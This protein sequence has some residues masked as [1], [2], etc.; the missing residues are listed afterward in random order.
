[1][2][3]MKLSRP[4]LMLTAIL[5]LES[6]VVAGPLVP[7]AGTS[8]SWGYYRDSTGYVTVD[9]V[10][11][12]SYINLGSSGPSFDPGSSVS[13]DA[14]VDWGYLTGYGI[15]SR[16]ATISEWYI[17][18]ISPYSY[19]VDSLSFS[20]VDP[21]VGA[22][23]YAAL[24]IS[25][26]GTMAPPDQNDVYV[27]ARNL[28]RADGTETP[29]NILAQHVRTSGAST[30]MT[31]L[32]PV[33]FGEPEFFRL[34]MALG[35]TLSGAGERSESYVDYHHTLTLSDVQL[36]DSE[37]NPITDYELTTGSGATYPVRAVPDLPSRVTLLVAMAAMFC[38]AGLR[39]WS[40][41]QTRRFARSVR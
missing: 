9:T 11:G 23:G 32:F 21:N 40:Q 41:R 34:S 5:A 3:I 26:N 7:T 22:S 14:G 13:A 37:Y 18:S 19:F 8:I 16:P 27:L 25:V 35:V 4:L 28:G 38:M 24:E 15:V 39:A 36:F 17:L 20:P 2:S 10:T 33:V 29:V 1:M 30:Y 31:A 6:A 12:G